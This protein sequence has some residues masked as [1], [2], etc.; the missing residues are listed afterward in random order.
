MARSQ[1]TLRPPIL[2]GPMLVWQLRCQKKETGIS[3][4]ARLML[5]AVAIRAKNY[6]VPQC[7]QPAGRLSFTMVH[8]ASRLRPS[9]P[10]ALIPVFS[11][12]RFC[13][14]VAGFVAALTSVY[15]I[16][17]PLIPCAVAQPFSPISLRPQAPARFCACLSCQIVALNNLLPA[18][19]AHAA[20]H[21][22][23]F[24]VTTYALYRNQP[25][26]AVAG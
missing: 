12:C 11:D 22:A 25:P 2:A 3:F 23:A 5:N 14:R 20:P 6:R 16:R 8:I 15:R 10:L 18:A 9:A 17:S 19:V 7:V 4:C 21:R 26:I 1:Q 24:S 13:P